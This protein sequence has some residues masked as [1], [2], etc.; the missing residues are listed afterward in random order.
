MIEQATASREREQTRERIL[1]V[2]ARIIHRK[3]FNNAG[4]QEIL[5][6]AGIPKGSFYYYFQSKKDFGLQVIEYY[7]SQL[8]KLLQKHMARLDLPPLERLR[9]YFRD[10]RA[11]LEKE[12]CRGGCPVGNLAQEMADL[13][14]S[15]RNRL[16]WTFRSLRN[17]FAEALE[18][19]AERGDLG[20]AQ[21]PTE[22]AEFIMSSWQGSILQ[23]KV[24]KS[25]EP[26][27]RFEKLVFNRIF[28][29]PE[30]GQET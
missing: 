20:L 18:E 2:G 15:F 6:E 16:N 13:D 26:L 28:A 17:G 12:S 29:C 8:L 5:Q 23:V 3:G 11:G 19:A 1:R 9:L 27:K 22:L 25:T 4:I 30:E 10:I 21:S 7:E 14:E 24:A